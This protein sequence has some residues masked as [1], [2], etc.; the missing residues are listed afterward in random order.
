MNALLSPSLFRRL[1]ARSIDYFVWSV[2]L[3]IAN[4]LIFRISDTTV[5]FYYLFFGFLFYFVVEAIFMTKFK[6]TPGKKLFKI[7]MSP[8]PESFWENLKRS[9]WANGVGMGF[10]FVFLGLLTWPLLMIY[11]AKTNK[12]FWDRNKRDVTV[13]D[14]SF[15][16]VILALVGV[17]VIGQFM[18][19]VQFMNAEKESSQP[20]KSNSLI[21]SPHEE[22][23]LS[24]V[25]KVNYVAPSSAYFQPFIDRCV[26]SASV[27]SQ[28]KQFEID[29]QE[30]TR[31]CTLGA[32][33]TVPRTAKEALSKTACGYGI[34]FVVRSE[35]GDLPEQSS[36]EEEDFYLD[37]CEDED[38]K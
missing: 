8:Y 5:T 23:K 34:T 28:Y 35:K 33:S 12:I 6:T 10:G 18:A 15:K 2:V 21:D 19:Y 25:D 16:T 27:F 14:L 32:Y 30:L 29:Y 26:R 3:N 7:T 1:L 17:L 20:P 24:S 37:F 31:Y 9:L 11:Y 36:K 4:F 38:A 22:K 13:E